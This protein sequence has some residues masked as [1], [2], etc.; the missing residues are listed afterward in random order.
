MAPHNQSL[1]KGN[2]GKKKTKHDNA[3]LFDTSKNDETSQNKSSARD[4]FFSQLSQ[5]KIKNRNRPNISHLEGNM[6]GT[7]STKGDGPP[8]FEPSIDNNNPLLQ[9]S[10]EDGGNP[11]NRFKDILG[12][13]NDDN[14]LS[15]I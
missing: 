1:S 11:R 3:N 9:T 2:Y 7:Q 10:V 5:S 14:I 8:H 13:I 6:H 15:R 4:L 12:Q